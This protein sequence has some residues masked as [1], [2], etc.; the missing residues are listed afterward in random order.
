[1]LRR[2]EVMDA[3]EGRWN[4]AARGSFKVSEFMTNY[5]FGELKITWNRGVDFLN[6]RVRHFFTEDG[7]FYCGTEIVGFVRANGIEY[8]VIELEEDK[9][10]DSVLYSDRLQVVVSDSCVSTHGKYKTASN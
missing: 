4:G 6:T 10:I 5:K 1:M 9:S 7:W 8:R 2:I 3:E